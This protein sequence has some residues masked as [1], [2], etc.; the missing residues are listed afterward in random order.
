L[1]ELCVF[2]DNKYT[3]IS[4]NFG[5]Y[6]NISSNGVNDTTST[7]RFHPVEFWVLTS[8]MKMQCYRNVRWT[9]RT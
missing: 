9:F 3:H 7:H 2:F 6:L 4:T 5:I 8:N 1:R